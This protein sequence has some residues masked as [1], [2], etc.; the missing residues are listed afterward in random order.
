MFFWKF[1]TSA[2]CLIL[3]TTYTNAK[4]NIII[5]I[6]PSSSGWH[7]AKTNDIKAVATSAA[8][9]LM[10][11]FPQ[12]KLSPIILRNEEI[13]PKVLYKRGNNNEYIV[14]VDING[15]RWSQLSYQFSHELCH[16]LS[17]YN[18]YNRATQWLE[19]SI[20]EAISLLTLEKMSI[21]WQH[22]PP[23]PNWKSYSSSI[24]KYLNNMLQEKHRGQ[25]NNLS[26]WF[27]L[28]KESLSSYPYLR[29]KFEVIGT[30]IYRLIKMEKFKISTIQ[31]LNLGLSKNADNI[32][33][34][35]HEW[36]KNSPPSNKESV[37]S[38]AK[39]LGINIKGE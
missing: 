30:A 24:K 27:V 8:S 32:S 20:C 34:R 23:Y 2:L 39:L 19:E 6:R 18:K 4:D 21:Q 35:L 36:Y 26:N 5:D 28:N 15:R 1:V 3:I 14:I 12:K 33:A 25:S 16:I 13:G 29:D 9:N 37:L 11:Y 38:I 10:H 7:E 31:Y 22:T 17:N